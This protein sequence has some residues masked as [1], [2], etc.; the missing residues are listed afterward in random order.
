MSANGKILRINKG[1]F[2]FVVKSLFKIA[3]T[4]SLLIF[5]ATLPLW[6]EFKYEKMKIVVPHLFLHSYLFLHKNPLIHYSNIF[7]TIYI[8]F[9]FR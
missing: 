5:F 2:I 6:T 8:L 9:K 1:D 3:K 7:L 4:D